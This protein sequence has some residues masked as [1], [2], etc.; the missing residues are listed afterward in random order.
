MRS[1]RPRQPRFSICK[2]MQSRARDRAELLQEGEIDFGCGTAQHSIAEGVTI[3]RGNS[4]VICKQR[5]KLRHLDSLSLTLVAVQ[6]HSNEYGASQTVT[7]VSCRLGRKRQLS[8]LAT[9]D[10]PGQ[11]EFLSSQFAVKLR[12]V[13]SALLMQ[14]YSGRRSNFPFC[15]VVKAPILLAF[16]ACWALLTLASRAWLRIELRTAC[17][18][19]SPSVRS[20]D[21]L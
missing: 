4:S 13:A 15:S 9:F 6:R 11:P 17:N 5:L 14:L 1:L 2:P 20:C 21:T 19:R 8:N 10:A 3:G 18:T 16:L 12:K 7:A